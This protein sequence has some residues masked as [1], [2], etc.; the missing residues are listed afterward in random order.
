MTKAPKYQIANAAAMLERAGF[1]VD[2]AYSIASRDDVAA[3]AADREQTLSE[4]IADEIQAGV[5]NAPPDDAPVEDFIPPEIV[6]LHG[7]ASEDRPPDDRPA[8]TVNE[9]TA[10][11]PARSDKKFKILGYSGEHYYYFPYEKKQIVSLTPTQH[12]IQNLLQLADL[13]FWRDNY[14]GKD[15]ASDS[16]VAL[17]ASNQLIK[18][19]TTRGIFDESQSVRGCGA[20]M[21]KGRVVLHCGDRLYVDGVLT[22]I[23]DLTSK[24]TYVASARLMTPSD[25][26]LSNAE[27]HKLRMLCE[28]P[29]WETKLSGSLLAGW[30]VVAPICAALEWR[31]HI[32]VT[33]QA[34]SGKSTVMDKIIEKVLG[35]FA[36]RLDGG[37]TE[38]AIRN[39]MKY[40]AR[41]VIFDEAE[42]EGKNKNIM[43]GVMSLVRLASSGGKV[44]KY[45]QAQFTAR[46]MTCFSA[47]RPPIRE[48]ADETR[49][50]LL[51]LKQNRKASAVQ[52]YKDL[53]LAI[54]D[55]ITEGF[56]SRML[57]RI[58]I[59]MPVLLKNIATFKKAA[60]NV[61]KGARAADQIAPMLA[62][63]FFLHSTQEVTLERAEE[64][65]RQQDWTNHTTIAEDNDPTR[66]IQHLVKHV[67][68]YNPSNGTPIDVTIG[69]L[70]E[71]CMGVNTDIRK[72]WAEKTLRNYSILVKPTGVTVAN[73]SQHLEKAFKDTPWSV[74]WKGALEA[75]EGAEKINGVYFSA[76]DTQR[77]V[78]IPISLFTNGQEVF[79]IPL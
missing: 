43:Q 46:F 57:T 71:T 78:K 27:A 45:G 32:W 33:G 31:P 68:K 47:I 4:F 15:G 62:G 24:Y 13:N 25:T 49:I 60:N 53:L 79:E 70:I 63:L 39:I 55:T 37:T 59:N 44:G 12:N 11:A 66:C 51:K 75:I 6:Q 30:L 18:R 1:D 8:E 64:F 74:G 42:G 10:R 20:W 69:D 26:V 3:S 5:F 34:E 9:Q 28:M 2:T 77:A 14:G 16:K 23:I 67:I 73:R 40:D 65:V 36:L 50:S 72:D 54:D 61:I 56:S 38:P 35:G 52:D 17:A 19:A 58:L 7:E 48:F 29:S 22:N 21:D 76:G 41:P